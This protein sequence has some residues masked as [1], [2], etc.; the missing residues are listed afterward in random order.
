MV[1]PTAADAVQE[2]L[3]PAADAN[4]PLLSLSTDPALTAVDDPKNVL[5]RMV[6]SD[7]LQMPVLANLFLEGF[8]TPTPTPTQGILPG[9]GPLPGSVC[10]LYQTG[11]AYEQM[12]ATYAAAM[13]HKK[14]TLRASISFDPAKADLDYGALLRDCIGP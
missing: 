2:V 11:A 9:E 7:A 1:G 6:A 12:A 10:V 14:A 4:V 3:T 8:A 13:T 5:F